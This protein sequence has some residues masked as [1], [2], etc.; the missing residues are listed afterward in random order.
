MGR[1]AISVGPP[2]K[3]NTGAF[4]PDWIIREDRKEK[5]TKNLERKSGEMAPPKEIPLKFPIAAAPLVATTESPQPLLIRG[6]QCIIPQMG[7]FPLDIRIQNGKIQ[8]IGYDLI[9]DGCE[10]IAANGMYL[11]PGVVDPHTHVGLFDSFKAEVVTESRSALLN[12][13]TTMGVYLGGQKSYLKILEEAINDISKRSATDIFFHLAIFTRK[14]LE[15]IPIYY[16]RYGVKSFKAYMC[17]IPGLIPSLDEGFLLDLMEA[18]ANLRND[19]LLNIHA[20]NYHIVEWAT[21]RLRKEIPG[22]LP[23]EKWTETHPA[24]SEVEAVQR[25]VL[26]SEQMGTRIYFVHIS[27]EKTL[28]M[29]KNMRSQGKNFFVETT[30]PYLTLTDTTALGP[31]AKMVPPIRTEQDR[32]SLWQ[33]LE[34]DVI[35]TIGSDHTPLTLSEKKPSRRLWETMPG[36]PA[37][38]THVPALFDFALK[39]NFSLL[40]LV[41]K[42]TLNPAKIFGLYP[43]KGTLLPGSDADLVIID[44]RCER[45]VSP[46]NAASRSDFALHQGDR[47][48][49]WPAIVLKSGRLV[50]LDNLRGQREF[51]EREY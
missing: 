20:E 33:G 43:Q 7:M 26:L 19:A 15:E 21:Q 51:T 28:Q 25:A 29:I 18:V 41:E 23:L 22:E 27:S 14:Q 46:E 37:V 4:L 38:G 40:K 30:S 5:E 6:A 11:I 9:P 45:I 47:L 34:E 16:S 36:Y 17:G 2:S 13:V 8:K 24:F 49:G 42:I 48:S 44:P 50:D 3:K 31:L 1:S 32:R 35:D 10:V 12:G 39:N